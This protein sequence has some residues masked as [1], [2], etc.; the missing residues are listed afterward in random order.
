MS[1]SPH[2]LS[3]LS[4]CRD[5]LVLLRL[6]FSLFLLP[7]YL[8]ALNLSP[9]PDSAKAWALFVLLHVL[10]YP[11]SNGYNSWVDRDTTPIGGLVAPPAPPRLLWQLVLLMDLLALGWACWLGWQAGL[12]VALFIAASRAYSA[13]WPRLKR[14]PWVSFW[15]VALGQGSITFWTVWTSLN[16]RSPWS[17]QAGFGALAA[18]ALVGAA[19]P[20]SQIYQH[21]EDAERG[22]LTLS[23]RL[24]LRGTLLFS[25]AAFG[26][27]AVLLLALFGVWGA[28][29][30]LLCSLPGLLVF[31]HF[32]WQSWHE[33]IHTSHRAVMRVQLLNAL[34]LNL[35]LLMLAGRSW[36][37]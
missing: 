1:H 30:L 36:L 8:L 4:I 13:P 11:A 9:Q 32:V 21:A 5:T 22:D 29:P 25:A 35:G 3:T 26:L 12:G 10:V 18:A 23:R 7:V 14:L 33:P 2:L 31:V 20:L 16:P 17:L 19:Y 37:A 27:G 34:G 15:L 28:L 6:P 24:G